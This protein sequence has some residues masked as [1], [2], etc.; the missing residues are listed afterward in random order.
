MLSISSCAR[1]ALNIAKFKFCVIALLSFNVLNKLLGKPKLDNVL[2]S[3]ALPK[4]TKSSPKALLDKLTPEM[5]ALIKSS[6]LL[7]VPFKNSLLFCAAYIA[8]LVVLRKLSNNTEQSFSSLSA[9]KIYIISTSANGSERIKK[10]N[11][12]TLNPY[13]L[14][15]E[16]YLQNME[17]NTYSLV[18]GEILLNIL[19]SFYDAFDSHIHQINKKPIIGTDPNRKKLDDLMSVI[20]NELLNKFIKIN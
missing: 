4:L 14:T 6:M 17:P 16:D 12:S 3:S 11:F 8:L 19:K 2:K 15:Q 13:E 18:R 7:Y 10:V 5:S 1:P 20:E 9:D